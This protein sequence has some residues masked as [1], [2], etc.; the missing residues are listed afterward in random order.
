MLGLKLRSEF[1]S[2]Q[3]SGTVVSLNSKHPESFVNLP[4]EKALEVTYPSVDLIQALEACFGTDNRRY[5]VI[6][7]E[8]GQGPLIS[9]CYIYH[10]L[11]KSE[12]VTKHRGIL[13]VTNNCLQKASVNR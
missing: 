4:T 8:R 5:L 13:I 12:Q 6:M 9:H 11:V 7:G 2:P 10:L 1:S 3:I